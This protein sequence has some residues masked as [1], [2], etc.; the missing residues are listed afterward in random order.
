M[1]C[2]WTNCLDS[3]KQSIISRT[4]QQHEVVEGY[5]AIL[6]YN[7]SPLQ[8]SDTWNHCKE[9]IEAFP[10][11]VYINICAIKWRSTVNWSRRYLDNSSI[12]CSS[13]NQAA[14]SFL[15]VPYFDLRYNYVERCYIALPNVENTNTKTQWEYTSKA[16]DPLDVGHQS[17][18]LNEWRTF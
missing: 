3:T 14:F 13:L 15:T 1:F 4:M 10:D 6:C 17:C 18:W 2:A 12:K 11:L 5:V 8:K 9:T 16:S 7:W